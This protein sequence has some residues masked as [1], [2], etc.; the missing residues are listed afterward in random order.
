MAE[1]I[2]V[3]DAPSDDALI[4]EIESKMEVLKLR[5]PNLEGKANKKERT[6]VNKDLYNLENDEAYVA[7]MKRR[8]EG[9]RS[10]AAAATRPFGDMK[11]YQGDEL[12]VEP[13]SP[14][15]TA[16]KCRAPRSEGTL[17]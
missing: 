11:H 15:S 12:A 17:G 14:P 8:L 9:G 5:L 2:D 10:A 7:A 4:A 6:Q 3:G 13:M 16:N 1:P